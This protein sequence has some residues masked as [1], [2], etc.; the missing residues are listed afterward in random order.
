MYVRCCCC[1]I[2][3]AA[4]AS[5]TWS[6]HQTHKEETR[7]GGTRM[8]TPPCPLS[9]C[10]SHSPRPWPT[11]FATPVSP[12]RAA[13]PSPSCGTRPPSAPLLSAPPWPPLSSGAAGH[14]RDGGLRLAARRAQHTGIW[15][16][17]DRASVAQKASSILQRSRVTAVYRVNLAV[18]MYICASIHT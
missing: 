3:T 15:R 2:T 17:R 6:I 12:C 4:A 14:R 16:R 13:C 8:A 5:C 18:D 9:F 7:R 10:F 1:C 11:W